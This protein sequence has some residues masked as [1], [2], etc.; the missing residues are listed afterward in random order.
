MDKAQRYARQAHILAGLSILC[1]FTSIIFA[2]IAI[3]LAT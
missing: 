3:I 2:I 1:A